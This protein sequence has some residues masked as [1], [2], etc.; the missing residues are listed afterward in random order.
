V[1]GTPATRRNLHTSIFLDVDVLEGINRDLQRKYAAMQCEAAAEE[2]RTEDA[3]VVFLAYGTSSRIARTAVDQLRADGV[4]AGL[5]RPR[6]LFPF[7]RAA[8]CR[9]VDR[10]LIVV[11]MSCGQFQEDVLGQ[12]AAGLRRVPELPLVHR[13]G[14]VLVSLDAVM[15]AARKSL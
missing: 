12:F 13:M 9:L 14:G 8:L 4:R 2:Y 5:F 15:E 7:P 6:T 10:K 3:E 1:Q 11:E